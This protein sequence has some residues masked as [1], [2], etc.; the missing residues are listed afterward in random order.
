MMIGQGAIA[1]V[2]QRYYLS[3]APSGGWPAAQDPTN[4]DATPDYDEWGPDDYWECADWI[5][6]HTA[7]KAK[8]G[9]EKADATFMPAWLV[10]DSAKYLGAGPLDCRSFNEGFRDYFKAEGLLDAMYGKVTWIKPIG[11]ATDVVS[12][13]SDVA[14]NVAKGAGTLSEF[15]ST[16][17]GLAVTVGAATLLL[18]M[19]SRKR[20]LL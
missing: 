6:W 8:Y 12:K 15:L 1:N 20:G 13:S 19:I 10:M 2:G 14:S 7:L 3:G 11:A 4:A 17:V 16:P 5:Q 18:V 9:K